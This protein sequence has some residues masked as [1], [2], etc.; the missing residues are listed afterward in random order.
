MSKLDTVRM[1]YKL[2]NLDALTIPAVNGGTPYVRLDQVADIFRE[3][4]VDVGFLD[5]R[6]NQ[7]LNNN[8]NDSVG[9]Y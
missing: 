1:I 5:A 9:I 7:L 3:A 4:K 8:I 6:I 2:S